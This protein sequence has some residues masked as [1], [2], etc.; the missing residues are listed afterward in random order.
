MPVSTVNRT[1]NEGSVGYMCPQGYS[2]WVLELE[3]DPKQNED[4]LFMDV[5][6]SKKLYGKKAGNKDKKPCK[7]K[8]VRR[9]R[10]VYL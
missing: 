4:C 7:E 2:D 9:L 1:V 8:G 5:M 10:C 3:S 6:L